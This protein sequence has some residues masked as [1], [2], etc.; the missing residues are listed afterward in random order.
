MNYCQEVKQRISMAKEAFNRRRSISFCGPLENKLR[1]R[2]VKSF[3]WSVALY[4]TES[5]TLRRNEQKRL[6]VF[7]IWIRRKLECKEASEVLCVECSV[8]WYRVLDTT[9]E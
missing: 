8:V 2:L 4:G 9:K 7:E 6:E 5:S 1:K 3:V